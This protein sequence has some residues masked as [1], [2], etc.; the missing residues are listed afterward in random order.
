M[1]ECSS[2]DE[3][4][5]RHNNRYMTESRSDPDQDTRVSHRLSWCRSDV[6][7]VKRGQAGQKRLETG[8]LIGLLVL[9]VLWWGV[10][11]RLVL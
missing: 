3:V 7:R 4:G 1:T 9:L 8:V 2:C 10:G 6:K 11:R 5:V